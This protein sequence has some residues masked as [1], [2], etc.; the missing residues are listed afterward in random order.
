VTKMMCSGD[1]HIQEPWEL[2]AERLPKG[3]RER[4]TGIKRLN[5]DLVRI[6]VDGQP[7][8]DHTIFRRPDGS[9]IEAD[10]A[11]RIRDLEMDG[12][13]AE[14]LV[15]NAVG[16][17]LY[18]IEDP[19]YAMACS[20]V[21]NGYMAEAY[22][23]SFPRQIPLAV[24]PLR[25][26]DL[27]VA[28]IERAAT[29]GFRGF[30]LPAL[31]P[32]P[33]HR[34]IYEPIWQVAN[35]HGMPVSFHV[36]TGAFLNDVIGD[37]FGA[38]GFPTQLDDTAM[39]VMR[40]TPMPMNPTLQQLK[41]NIGSLIGS[42]VAERYPDLHFVCVESGASWLA[43]TMEHMDTAWSVAPAAA[44]IYETGAWQGGFQMI[45]YSRHDVVSEHD[46]HEEPPVAERIVGGFANK[47]WPFPLTPSDYVRRQFHC[48][49]IAETAPIQSRGFTG[50]APLIWGADYPHPE[51]T[52]PRSRVTTDRMCA[53]IDP[54]DK[55]AI[56]GGNLAKLY[57]FE[58]P[59]VDEVRGAVSA[60]SSS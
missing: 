32:E 49:F 44:A 58:V 46:E 10:P 42:G 35:A 37:M 14:T 33:Y 31:P 30:N 18:A 9:A 60:A 23:P 56:L 26:V 7:Y 6:V 36:G 28:E 57:D 20:R 21:I 50:V 15:P 1:G 5:E 24:I 29:L 11:G 13:W 43:D 12:V 4:F 41:A 51:G 40:T 19:E 3:M 38:G 39:T 34:D 47:Q 45:T 48:T 54:A 16:F 8:M 22:L 59:D 2:W 25:D 52:W 53:G 27:A 55:E 17:A